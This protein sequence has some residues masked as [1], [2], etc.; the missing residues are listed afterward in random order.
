MLHI[1]CLI[2]LSALLTANADSVYADEP[3]IGIVT[4]TVVS[5]SGSAVA[6][7]DVLVL[8]DDRPDL[9]SSPQQLLVRG[10]TDRQGAFALPVPRS[11]VFS[12]AIHRSD[13]VHLWVSHPES[14]W[15][16][17]R[18]EGRLPSA[19]LKLTLMEPAPERLTVLAPGGQPAS[20]IEVVIT[21]VKIDDVC[22]PV[23]E[24]LRERFTAAT[25]KQGQVKLPGVSRRE[26]L[27]ARF[28]DE[29][30]GSQTLYWP[31]DTQFSGEV[32]LRSAASITGRVAGDLPAGRSW[33][34]IE[35]TL[36]TSPVERNI[37]VPF[38]F[39]LAEV[40]VGRDGTFSVPALATGV[41]IVEPKLPADFPAV[42]RTPEGLFVS[43][44]S[45]VPMTVLLQPATRVTGLI[46][47]PETRFPIPDVRVV[48]AHN[49][50]ERY[51]ARTDESGQFAIYLPS[52]DYYVRYSL[53]SPYHA[54]ED[55]FRERVLIP[56]NATQ[57]EFPPPELMKGKTL[58]GR[59]TDP[60][61]DPVSGMFVSAIWNQRNSSG[62][63]QAATFTDEQGGFVLE[64]V[65]PTAA[66]RIQPLVN[67]VPVSDSVLGKAGEIRQPIEFVYDASDLVFLTG[68]IVDDQGQPVPGADYQ[69]STYS[70]YEFRRDLEV[71]GI[72]LKVSNEL[73][74]GNSIVLHQGRTSA[75]GTFTTPRKFVDRGSYFVYT[76]IDG[77]YAG[78][79]LR[80]VPAAS[81][82]NQFAD[83]VQT[84][85]R[86]T[87]FREKPR[88][89]APVR[90][91]FSALVTNRDGEP[92]SD[93]KAIVWTLGKR[94]Q[95]R[96]DKQGR[97][98]MPQVFKPGLWVFVDA[99]G[100]RFF[101][102]FVKPAGVEHRITLL[103]TDEPAGEPMK[104]ITD[105]VN[106]DVLAEARQDFMKFMEHCHELGDSRCKHELMGLIPRLDPDLGMSCLEDPRFDASDMG[107]AS[108]R[109]SHRNRVRWSAAMRYVKYDPRKAAETARSMTLGTYRVWGLCAVAG[110]LPAG[111]QQ[112]RGDLLSDALS[113]ARAIE[114]TQERIEALYS[115]ASA[116][117]DL[118]EAKRGQI[119]LY[120]AVRLAEK[121]LPENLD[122]RL[123]ESANAYRAFIARKL[124]LYDLPAALK[125]IPEAN[126]EYT[127]GRYYGGVAEAVADVKPADAVRILEQFPEA[128]GGWSVRVCYRMAK[129]DYERAR[130]LSEAINN[131]SVRFYCW[132]VMAHA[133]ADEDP[134]KARELL[135]EAFNELGTLVDAGQ[136]GGN[137]S[138]TPLKAALSLLP[139]VEQ[140][141]PDRLREYFWRALSFRQNANIGKEMSGLDYL[142]TDPVLG[143]FLARY[144]RDVAAV[145]IRPHYEWLSPNVDE[146]EYFLFGGLAAVDPA[147][148]VHLVS[149]LPEKTDY[150]RTLK[151]EA[152]NEIV[153]L[154]VNRG[155]DGWNDLKDNQ[156]LF[157]E[158]DD[159][160]L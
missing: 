81:E 120:E 40:R 151:L 89:N 50:Y 91:S 73:H 142:G 5:E 87:S 149:Q 54:P 107:K 106:D 9:V 1:I 45:D 111:E 49:Y 143:A 42:A 104:T 47:D 112:L 134:Q 44:N 64:G 138:Y 14:G 102:E 26:L 141:D 70:E 78:A 115:V 86:K 19:D 153:P 37:D 127:V 80:L 67:A 2:C 74:F 18:T 154:L 99:E 77:K 135:A 98:H 132:G 84:L 51:R 96:T 110:A 124:A 139:V 69:I 152:W 72:Q 7:A 17:T 31:Y 90:V 12:G 160:G 100:Y 28:R 56:R 94:L 34:E 129:A 75:D 30:F 79:S 46:L 8:L 21:E 147:E 122:E 130:E 156:Y 11:L 85:D 137:S 76:R 125:L 48:F 82:T 53:P 133:I 150:D 24:F 62:K 128:R 4:G 27:G 43:R 108:N 131:P 116:M 23:P 38:Q 60:D 3:L 65:H 92:V 83:V 117:I 140:V 22:S 114:E 36:G 10:Q 146:W 109:E 88:Y 13:E 93:A 113:T 61:G 119:V 20:G 39:G 63:S 95:L 158:I 32:T 101:G 126:K 66:L 157:R 155:K 148:A 118:G 58:T 16:V 121:P 15:T 97:I 71:D 52:N 33:D 123:V 29:R 105:T 103:R 55:E 159:L 136:R 59:V 68:K 145:L 41:M 57:F 25:D 6:G 144:D 35:L